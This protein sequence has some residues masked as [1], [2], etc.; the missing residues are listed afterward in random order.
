MK[1]RLLLGAYLLYASC[2]A[3]LN[4]GWRNLISHERG[5]FWETI[6]YFPFAQLVMLL[7]ISFFLIVLLRAWKP[8]RVLLIVSAF[9]ICYY[10]LLRA[11][12]LLYGEA[13]EIVFSDLLNCAL[14]PTVSALPCLALLRRRTPSVSL[15]AL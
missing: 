4:L 6:I 15:S 5:G 7:P 3:A 11:R 12:A 2:W 14:V 1:K 13:L 9:Y 8:I 10:L